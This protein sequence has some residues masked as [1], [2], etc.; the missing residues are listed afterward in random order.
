MIV[1]HW[2]RRPSALSRQAL[3]VYTVLILYGSLYPFSGWRS[4]GI[5]PFAY[6]TDPLPQY[7]TAFDV[8]TNVLGYVP[9]G[10]L[11]VLAL[12]PRWRGALAAGIA[13]LG[14]ALLS[15]T[16]EAVQTYLP[17]RV[18]SNLDLTA[19]ALGA[20]LGAALFAPA[21]SMLL[22]RGLLRRTRF[23]WFE[24][25]AA[26]MIGLSALWPFATMYP[27]PYLFAVG[28]LPRV[29][30]QHLDPSMQDALIAWA[31]LAWNVA[32]WPSRIGNLFSGDAWDA[33]ITSLNLF[34]A[35]VLGTLPM[36]ERAPRMRLLLGLVLATLCAKAG[37]TFLQ[38]RSGL[39]FD[40]VTPGALG[41]IACGSMAGLLSLHLSRVW[42]ASLAGCALVVALLLVNLLPANPYFDIV[43]ADWRQGRYIHFNGLSQWLAW[44]WPYAALGWLA[45]AAERAYLARRRG[46]DGSGGSDR[47]RSL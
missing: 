18:A 6:L 34:A 1:K 11:A 15:G 38:S 10:A 36:R 44:V 26:Y 28:D 8:I 2:Q 46:G 30:W 41:G 24:R 5:G 40:W 31:P 47:H 4:L 42:R 23:L 39:A 3:A 17:T 14:G 29:M 21:A 22:D 12:Y 37:A 43:L 32:N 16:M 19:N 13:F 27:A 7:L 9:F 35:L 45:S 20:L 33:L 25:D